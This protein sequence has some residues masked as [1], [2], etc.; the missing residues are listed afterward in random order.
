MAE[1]VSYD[2]QQG[3]IS[4]LWAPVMGGGVGE[5]TLGSMGN[6]IVLDTLDILRWLNWSLMMDGRVISATSGL[7]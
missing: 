6:I 4:Y 1:L 7:L 2:G 3:Y 5:D